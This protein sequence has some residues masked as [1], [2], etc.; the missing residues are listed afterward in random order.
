[1]ILQHYAKNCIKE[2]AMITTGNSAIRIYFVTLCM[3]FMFAGLPG[4]SISSDKNESK[5][6][7]P[8]TN[9]Y[10]NAEITTKIIPSAN[11]TYGYDILMYGRPLVHQPN[12]PGLPGN[13]GFATREKAQKVADFVVKKI[14]NNEMPPTVT[15]E[16][17][18]KMGVMK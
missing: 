5:E 10:A 7:I 13:E 18:N 14:K 1:M 12:I 6:V 3:L 2:V 17:L 4:A 15:A 9:P 11:N 8:Q 16:D